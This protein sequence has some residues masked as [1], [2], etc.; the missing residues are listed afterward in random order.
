MMRPRKPHLGSGRVGQEGLC[1][2]YPGGQR[3]GAVRH[4]QRLTRASGRLPDACA[5]AR[6]A[7][8]F[9]G[10]RGWVCMPAITLFG[11]GEALASSFLTP[12]SLPACFLEQDG[13]S[14]CWAATSKPLSCARRVPSDY[15]AKSNDTP[16]AAGSSILLQQGKLRL[17]MRRDFL[18]EGAQA[19]DQAAGEVVASPSLGVSKS[20]SDRPLAGVG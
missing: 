1:C 3:S 6:F 19:W 17:G 18:T 2:I 15:K 12:L 4:A 10:G 20:R 5:I 16:W 14:L 9:T 8:H 13:A 11:T 7:A